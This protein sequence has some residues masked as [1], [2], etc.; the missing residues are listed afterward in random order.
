MESERIFSGIVVTEV[1]S[2]GNETKLAPTNP[3]ME[4]KIPV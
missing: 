2:H 3:E 1:V 4:A